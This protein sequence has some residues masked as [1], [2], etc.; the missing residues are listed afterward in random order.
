MKENPLKMF[1][2]KKQMVACF[3][4]LNYIWLLIDETSL[5]ALCGDFSCHRLS[6]LIQ[7]SNTRPVGRIWH[8]KSFYVATDGLKDP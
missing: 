2:L 4:A 5:V 7:V 6:G 3:Y 8:A 1:S